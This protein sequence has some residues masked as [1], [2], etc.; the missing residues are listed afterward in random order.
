M[1]TEQ[2]QAVSPGFPQ[3]VSAAVTQLKEKL[4]RDYERIYPGLREIIRLILQE[5]ERNAWQ[6]SSFPHLFLPDLV[7]AHV[8]RL[9]LQPVET[10]AKAQNG[11]TVFAEVPIYQAALAVCGS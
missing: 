8:A 1:Q 11:P 3:T 4:Q 2:L 5:E 7:E 6:L 10:E 9:G